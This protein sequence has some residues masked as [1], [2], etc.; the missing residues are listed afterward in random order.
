LEPSWPPAEILA[1][2]PAQKIS[3]GTYYW[4]TNQRISATCR[5]VQR[6][7]VVEVTAMTTQ[8]EYLTRVEI[9]QFLARHGFPIAKSTIDHLSRPSHGYAGPKPVG[10]WGNKHLYRP[11]EV[12]RWAQNR[13]RARV[14]GHE[15]GRR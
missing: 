14:V 1:K 13:F 2:I 11:A 4:D 7:A 8:P 10:L 3:H 6:A 5:A 15:R 9:P 12:L